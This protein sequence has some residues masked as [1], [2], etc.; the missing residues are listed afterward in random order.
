M[1]ETLV[2]RRN[3]RCQWVSNGNRYRTRV[4]DANRTCWNSR[5]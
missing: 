2:T 5:S 1:V 4:H 3:E